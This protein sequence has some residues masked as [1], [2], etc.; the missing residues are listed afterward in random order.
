MKQNWLPEELGF[1]ASEETL[2]KISPHFS[3]DKIEFMS[4]TVGPFKAGR[5]VK[6]PLWLA[7][8]LHSS[9]SCAIL[10]PKWLNV[11]TLKKIILN[12]KNEKIGLTRIHPFYIE[13]SYLFFNHSPQSIQDI[14]HVRSL[15]SDIWVRRVEKIRSSIMG[16]KE[17]TTYTQ[18]PNATRMEIHYFREPIS[19]IIALLSSI[20][21]K[22]PNDQQD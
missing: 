6:V 11:S 13:I 18:L 4:T 15:I 7:L 17:H 10:P 21:E 22:I 5:N 12:E 1:L 2:V 16:I 3:T 20:S 9:Q 8:F 14:D 19:K